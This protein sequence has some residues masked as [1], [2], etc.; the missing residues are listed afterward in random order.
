MA[1]GDCVRAPPDGISSVGGSE[2]QGV[3]PTGRELSHSVMRSV[4]PRRK[5][6]LHDRTGGY[7][8]RFSQVSVNQ[9]VRKHLLE[10]LGA[11]LD[12]TGS[13]TGGVVQKAGGMVVGVAR[14]LDTLW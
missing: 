12:F 11:S 6:L 8:K 7:P 5:A 10:A 2:G 1:I 14:S 4:R 3:G 9:S 13:A